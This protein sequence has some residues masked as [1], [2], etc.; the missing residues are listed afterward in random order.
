[1]MELLITIALA[2]LVFP[3]V[4]FSSS[5]DNLIP[6][7][8]APDIHWS[9]G[10]VVAFPN[11]TEF[12]DATERRDHFGEPVFGAS[13]TPVNDEDVVKAVKVAVKNGIPFLATGGRH[14]SGLGYSKMQGGIAIDLSRFTAFKV[15][16]EDNTV[17][18]GGAQTVLGFGDQLSAAGLMLPHGTC[19]CPGYMG[20][21]VGGGVGRYY[22]SLGLVSDSMVSARVVTATGDIV[23][24]SA[25]LNADLFWGLRGAGAN[26]GIIL[27]ATYQAVRK[28]DHWD[29]KALTVDLV[30]SADKTLAY[31]EHLA[32]LQ[33][34]DQLPGHVSGMHIFRYNA[35]EDQAELFVN[36]V[37]LGSESEG[38]AFLSQFM[39][40]DPYSIRNYVYIDTS[41]LNAVAGDGLGQNAFCARGIYSN[42]YSSNLR[43]YTASLFQESFATI[44]EFYSAWPDARASALVL[45]I[46][47]NQAVVAKPRDFNAF[48]WRDTKAFISISAAYS[49]AGLQ[50][51]TVL[52]AG[53]QLGAAL[54]ASWIE[55]GGYREYGGACY[56]NYAHGDESLRTIYGE[57]LPRLLELKQKWDP[58]DVFAFKNNL[59]TSLGSISSLWPDGMQVTFKEEETLQ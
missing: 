53:D 32:M 38:H 17:T 24:A 28:V 25:A 23:E 39:E 31:F 35:T 12:V 3:D 13:I 41:Q 7:L 33:D 42:T 51:Q 16:T 1:M 30:Y 20:L 45:E 47:P 4:C 27:N 26:F 54:R 44:E 56:I 22:G 37:W 5:L 19:S 6:I 46:F 11:T 8:T 43:T 21:A 34:A 2:W 14:G 48:A 40:L 58:S 15:H 29:G 49:D 59:P 36:W 57:N 10:T 52:D 50:N 18:L 9:A 55:Q